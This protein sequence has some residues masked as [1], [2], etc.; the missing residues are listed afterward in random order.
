MMCAFVGLRSLQ[1][2][3]VH[4]SAQRA[5]WR[6][7]TLCEPLDG[8]KRT[9]ISPVDDS[10]IFTAGAISPT[11][12][13]SRSA[14]VEL[15]AE[16]HRAVVAHELAHV[17]NGDIWRR[18]ALAALSQFALPGVGAFAL[19]LWDQSAE[20]ICDQRAAKVVGRP[21]V[22]AGAIL[23]V[24]RSARHS[25][26]SSKQRRNCRGRVARGCR[27]APCLGE[28]KVQSWAPTRDG[29]MWLAPA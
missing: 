11:I 12:V 16:Q 29:A 15:D 10:V 20:R 14:C 19:R 17:E 6:L 9:V 7:R 26:E 5:A 2:L 3:A 23:A 28:R 25:S 1:L 22:V 8:A 4:A 24:A 27:P 18:A 13:I 21:S